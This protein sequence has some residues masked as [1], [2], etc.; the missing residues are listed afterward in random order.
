L[1][2]GIEL[3]RFHRNDRC[4]DRGGWLGGSKA[5][6]KTPMS[7]GEEYNVKIEDV[8][9]QAK[10]GIDKIEDVVNL[11]SNASPRESVM[12]SNVKLG[13]GDAG[14]NLCIR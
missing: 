9:R 12:V 14:P 8:N 4:G 6:A 11:V 13:T 2:F 5:R 1:V 10:N 7:V 3:K